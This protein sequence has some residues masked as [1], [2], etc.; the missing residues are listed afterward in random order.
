MIK[1]VLEEK[2]LFSSAPSSELYTSIPQGDQRRTRRRRRRAKVDSDGLSAESKKRRLSDEQLRFLE[3]NF[4]EERKLESGRKMQ[5][6]SKLGLD[7][8]QVAVWFQNRRARWKN[9]Q[10]EEEYLKLKTKLDSVVVEKCHLENEVLSLKERLSEAEE[11][12]KRLSKGGDGGADDG[13]SPSSSSTETYQPPPPPPAALGEFGE[14]GDELLYI[15]EDNC[16]IDYGY[17]FGM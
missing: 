9:K 13:G 10:M 11:K 5:L 6:A 8:K 16:V 2:M 17:L 15:N 7:P 14:M 12:I 1:Q 3:I 4:G